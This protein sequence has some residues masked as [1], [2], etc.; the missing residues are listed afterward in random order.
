MTHSQIQRADPNAR[1][2]AIGLVIAATTLGV[3]LLIL[4]GRWSPSVSNW[5]TQD[6]SLTRSRAQVVLVIVGGALALPLL[7]FAVYL[8][9]LGRRIVAAKRFPPPA[10]RLIHDTPIIVGP[11]AELRGHLAKGMAISLV[12]LALALIG[13]L[14]RLAAMSQSIAKQR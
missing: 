12:I 7:A 1:K 4:A 3:G 6:P 14:S 9:Q 5:V 10:M 8:W 2:L 13:L 11:A